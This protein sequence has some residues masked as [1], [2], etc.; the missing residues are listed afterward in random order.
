MG[1]GG[2]MQHASSTNRK[3]R[4]HREARRERFK[5]N[6][7]EDT[8]LNGAQSE[9]IEFPELHE[10]QVTQ[11]RKRIRIRH[12]KRKRNRV[13]ILSIALVMTFIVIGVLYVKTQGFEYWD[14]IL[15]K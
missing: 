6:Y 15:P 7:S 14:T 11:E 9:K 10:E 1:G 3:D 12:L 8:L 13:W 4:A 5:G 2:F